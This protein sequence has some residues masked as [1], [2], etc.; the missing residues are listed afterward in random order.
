[1]KR[2]RLRSW[3]SIC[4]GT[5]S[6]L[7]ASHVQAGL[8]FNL[9]GNAR[10]NDK[11]RLVDHGRTIMTS[12]D[13]MVDSTAAVWDRPLFDSNYAQ[14]VNGGRFGGKALELTTRSNTSKQRKQRIEFVVRSLGSTADY[15]KYYYYGFSVRLDPGWQASSKGEWGGFMQVGQLDGQYSPIGLAFREG[16][17]KLYVVNNYGEGQGQ[18]KQRTRDIVDMRRGQWYDFVL[19][20]KFI[21]DK[22]EG[23]CHVWWKE[24][25]QRDWEQVGWHDVQVGYRK[26]PWILNPIHFGI[27]RANSNKFQRLRVDEMRSSGYPGGAKVPGSG[28]IPHG[29]WWKLQFDGSKKCIDN[30]ANS[31]NGSNFHQWSCGGGASDVNRQFRFFTTR[32]GQWH[33]ISR[34][35]AKAMDTYGDRNGRGGRL[36]KHT[37]NTNQNHQ[38][39]RLIDRGGSKFSLQSVAS[40]N[41]VDRLLG[42]TNGSPIVQWGCG[43]NSNRLRQIK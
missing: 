22:P 11:H 21:P 15:G 8:V 26:H 7:S 10:L 37:I 31:S 6:V 41:C 27:Y 12:R 9:E 13:G 17:T 1:M 35:N 19:G 34:R 43:G 25:G 18:F 33:V 2:P 5:L 39:F 40:G 20:F 24:S 29:G 3:V 14:V 42:T 4:I 32:R 16:T 30:M 28:F 38:R 36:S 23:F